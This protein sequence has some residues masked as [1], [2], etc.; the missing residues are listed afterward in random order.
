[1]WSHA[2]KLAYLRVDRVA[3]GIEGNPIGVGALS[4]L[5]DA[6]DLISA[7]WDGGASNVRGVIHRAVVL[8]LHGGSD[9]KHGQGLRVSV[10]WLKTMKAGR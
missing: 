4:Q 3:H 8:T 5:V 6:G 9:N 1:M 7:E 10:V 2:Q